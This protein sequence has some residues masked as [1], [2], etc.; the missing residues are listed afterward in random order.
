MSN[1][2]KTHKLQ[3]FD[4]EVREY[5]DGHLFGCV[6][7]SQIL[8][9]TPK[10]LGQLFLELGREVEALGFVDVRLELEIYDC[11]WNLYATRPV[12]SVDEVGDY[13]ERDPMLDDFGLFHP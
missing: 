7:M 12:Q 8:D 10:D 2:I 3:S 4:A 13:D 11:F 5:Q 1:N 9:T 6:F